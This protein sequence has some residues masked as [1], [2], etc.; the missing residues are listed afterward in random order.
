MAAN[1]RPASGA[2]VKLLEV[3]PVDL[4]HHP[5]SAVSARTSR[6][7][8][9]AALGVDQGQLQ[10]RPDGG[11]AGPKPCRPSSHCSASTRH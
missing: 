4:E 7:R 5:G 9:S 11:R 2:G 6:L 1:S 3:E 8:G 10:L